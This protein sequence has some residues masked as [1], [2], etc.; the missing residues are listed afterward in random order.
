MTFS[1]LPT[2][3]I[4]VRREVFQREGREGLEGGIRPFTFAIFA[5]KFLGGGPT[6]L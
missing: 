5:F 1:A 2:V 4:V 6:A 3:R